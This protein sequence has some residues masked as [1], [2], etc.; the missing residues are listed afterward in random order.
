MAIGRRKANMESNEQLFIDERNLLL[1]KPSITEKAQYEYLFL[2][3]DEDENGK[4]IA[5]F[6]STLKFLRICKLDDRFRSSD[7]WKQWGF[8]FEESI[9]AS[10]KRQEYSPQID[11]EEWIKINIQGFLDNNLFNCFEK[12]RDTIISLRK[13]S[14]NENKNS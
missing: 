9:D 10:N 13:K 5:R 7:L 3:N 11:G 6:D 4:F 14:E 12:F 8:F 1:V 2:H